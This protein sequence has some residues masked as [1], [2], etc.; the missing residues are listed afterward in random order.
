MSTNQNDSIFRTF[1][2]V[3]RKLKL[4]IFSCVSHV[5]CQ[6]PRENVLFH[7]NN[8]N[9]TTSLAFCRFIFILIQHH[10]DMALGNPAPLGLLAFGMTTMLLMYVEMGWVD[11]DFEVLIYGYAV[12][13]GGVCQFLVGIFELFKGSSFS[14]AAFCSYGAFWLGWAIVFVERHRT[15]STFDETSYQGGTTLFLFQWS[16]LTCC[17]FVITLRKNIC[18]ICV[19]GLLAVT[20]FMLAVATMSGNEGVKKAGGY[21]GFFTAVAAFYTGVAELIN[22]EWGRHVLP[23]LSP[24]HTPERKAISKESILKLISYDKRTNSMFLQFQGLQ[25]NRPEDVEAIKEG[26]ESAILYADAPDN[27][28][29]VVADYK[30][31]T[32]AKEL[33]DDYWTM[34]HNLERMY[35]LSVRRFYVSSFGTRSHASRRRQTAILLNSQQSASFAEQQAG[36]LYGSAKVTS[37]SELE[38]KV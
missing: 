25:I 6:C 13:F 23:G 35:Y 33:E 7:V 32:I 30:D 14:F 12:F 31:V 26:V 9:T 15:T 27:K 5:K 29:H 22:E 2:G 11:K 10:Q 24:L 8:S 4:L 36:T 18:L 16:I 21:F 20:F 28:V 17:F 19:F 34:A 3:R 38:E 37:F 1:F